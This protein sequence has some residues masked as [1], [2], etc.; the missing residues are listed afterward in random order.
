[1]QDAVNPFV[2]FILFLF[3]FPRN[4]CALLVHNAGY[5]QAQVVYKDLCTNVKGKYCASGNLIST[6]EVGRK[7]VFLLY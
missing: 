6:A 1:M 4:F 5:L 3:F 7:F 2:L